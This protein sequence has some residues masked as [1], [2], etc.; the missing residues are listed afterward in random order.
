MRLPANHAKN[1]P[2]ERSML[3]NQITGGG[4]IGGEASKRPRL[5]SRTWIVWAAVFGGII[6]LMIFKDRKELPGD[7]LTQYAFEELVESNQ[8]L[9]ATINYNAQ[10]S[11]LNEVV[12]KY[13]KIEDGR[14]VEVVFAEDG[15][16]MTGGKCPKCG[17]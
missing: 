4:E 13:Y 10:G 14:K 15:T 7:I 6:L 9:H 1:D 2:A 8:I 3:D 16:I 17:K 12:G 11:A 5:P